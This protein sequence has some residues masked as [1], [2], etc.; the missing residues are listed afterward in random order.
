MSQRKR[1][2]SEFKSKVAL[3][4]IQE[5][6]TL[7]EIASKYGVHP[8]QV[9]Q[10]KKQALK[11]MAGIFEKPDKTD[12]SDQQAQITKLHAKI[13]QLTMERDFLAQVYDRCR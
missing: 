1:Y 11:G 9:A 5:Q 10:W 8:N 7:A 3:E 4:A 2:S 13:G 6:S 12:A